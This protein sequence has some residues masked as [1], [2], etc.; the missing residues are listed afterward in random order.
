MSAPRILLTCLLWGWGASAFALNVALDVG[1][2]T[3]AG[4]TRRDGFTAGIINAIAQTPDG[5]LWLGTDFGL[6]RFD[7]VRAVP[8]QPP[9]GQGL[10]AN[11][12]YVLQASR[13]GSLW[14]GT[15]KGLARWYRDTLTQYPQLAG[16]YVIRLLEDREG[17]V[18]VGALG[19]PA[20]RL[21]EIHAVTVIC[22]G[23]DGRFGNGI[24]AL[25]EDSDRNLW[26]SVTDGIWR[27]KPGSPTFVA[28]TGAGDSLRAFDDHAG[29][30]EVGTARGIRELRDGKLRPSRLALDV[31]PFSVERLLRDRD[32]GLW[33]GTTDRGVIHLHDGR[34]D[35]FSRADGLSSD[36]VTG[37]FED[38]EGNVWVSTQSGL[39]RFSEPSVSIGGAGQGIAGS[40]YSVLA[41]SDE[42]M[43]LATNRGLQRV[44]QGRV[45]RVTA[46]S[47]RPDQV[48]ASLL[49]DARGQLWTSTSNGP[50]Y[51]DDDRFISVPGA[52]GFVRQFAQQSSG[53]LWAASQEGGLLQL[54]EK[55]VVRQLTW[56]SLGR[57][58]FATALVADPSGKGLWLGFYE[59][60]LMYVDGEVRRSYGE[61]DGF[62]ASVVNHLRF[63]EEGALWIS[64]DGGLS[65]FKDGRLTRLTGSSG[66][67]CDGAHW[68][69]LDDERALWLEM[70]CG[71]VRIPATE[72][73]TWI[74]A[75]ANPREPARVVDHIT[76]LDS[77]DG[78][79][80][81]LSVSNLHPPVARGGDGRLWFFGLEG[82]HTFDPRHLPVNTVPPP[83]YVERV[84]ADQRPYTVTAAISSSI[85]LPA[86]VRAVQIDYTALSLV[87]PAKMR[88]RYKLEGW[89]RDWQDAGTRRQA[90]YTN[91]PPRS[92]RFRVM[93]SNN[94][95][96]W[97]EAGAAVDFVIAPAYYQTGWFWAFAAGLV[98]AAAWGTHRLRLRIVETHQRQI[99]ALN[100]RLM[101][102][103]EQ[104][105]MRIAGE[106][107]DG[108][109]QE[110]L[111][112]TMMLG[113]ARRRMPDDSPAKATI[114]KV[115]EKLIQMGT[116]IRQIS[117]DL[118]PPVLQEAGLP[119]ALRSYCE[120]YS[121]GSGIAV[122]CETDEAAQEL[123]RGASLALYRIMQEAIGNAAKHA[124]PTRIRVELRRLNGAVSLTISDDGIG[125]DRSR[126][127]ASQGLGLITMRERAGQ[128]GGEFA[129]ES[130]PGRGTTVRVDIP[131]R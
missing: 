57:K 109:A 86:L 37:L 102:A 99:T 22:H 62:D 56:A 118:H 115:Q 68:S 1:Q 25:Y 34:S 108:V 33:I 114:D 60:G 36:A 117:H 12:V 49:R 120:Q 74:S 79:A 88:F 97:N 44:R 101:K 111:A 58:D 45:T 48:F 95:G 123:S 110:M 8:W 16:L 53:Q 54:D 124:A 87:A 43:W 113:T 23:E 11:D 29:V 69:I 39:D 75:S 3:H 125:F 64:T 92:Y 21:C 65:R 51:L 9:A 77:S 71:L 127:G 107:H 59:G 96:V 70:P 20:G 32:G 41:D 112:A 18:W 4:W 131:F 47:S 129:F 40:V 94:S 7:G 13:D 76:F 82:V 84:I 14:I 105:R 128:L 61:K 83:V 116:D 85:R 63:D 80:P 104:E 122:S 91:L 72:L 66:L 38:R 35:R 10:P 5:Y 6:L 30:L 46:G 50:G 15:S 98:A 67:P 90:F 130:A 78:V 73:Q 100:E 24:W 121:A 28:I 93:A 2:Y 27:W 126:L 103:Q 119:E 26:A 55:R 106:L 19:L 17:V 31:P 52:K 81:Q 42:T 89:D